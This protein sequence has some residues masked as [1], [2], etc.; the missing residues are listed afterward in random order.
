MESSS[1][2]DVSVVLLCITTAA[3]AMGALCE[4]RF[5]IGTAQMFSMYVPG[6]LVQTYAVHSR[7][8]ALTTA[9]DGSKYPPTTV[10][11]G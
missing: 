9:V 6:Y 2:S 11:T 8:G 10:P 1:D 4:E 3:A 7:N 5:Q